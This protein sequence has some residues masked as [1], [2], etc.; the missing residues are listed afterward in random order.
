MS[1][2]DRRG[3]WQGGETS[4]GKVRTHIIAHVWGTSISILFFISISFV[5][6][7]KKFRN[8]AVN[9]LPC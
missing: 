3:G 6:K 4:G 5:V 9:M 8:G 1:F 2:S 7:Q